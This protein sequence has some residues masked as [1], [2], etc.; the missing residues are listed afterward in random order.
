MTMH[1]TPTGGYGHGRSIA[2]AIDDP[3]K[4]HQPPTFVIGNRVFVAS[5]KRSVEHGGQFHV[6]GAFTMEDLETRV[7]RTLMLGQRPLVAVIHEPRGEEK[8]AGEA[9][10]TVLKTYPQCG[11]VLITGGELD[12]ATERRIGPHDFPA[13]VVS[14]T[15]V[16]NPKSLMASMHSAIELAARGNGRLSDVA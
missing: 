8:A 5:I 14:D 9:A 15:A 16:R 3:T 10:H 12:A 7:R 4:V 2:P 11:I 13:V 6:I 1:S